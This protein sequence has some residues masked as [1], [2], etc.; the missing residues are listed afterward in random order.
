MG[1][2]GLINKYATT[3]LS[4]ARAHGFDEDSI[5]RQLG[6]AYHD[7]HFSGED[8]VV[9]SREVKLL[10]Q[11]ELCGLTRNR[12]RI[13][14]FQM[15]CQLALSCSTLGAALD[16]AFSFYRLISEDIGFTL[17]EGGDAVVRIWLREPELDRH[18]MLY[19]WWAIFWSHFAGWLIGEE[20]PLMSA[21]FP[22][23]QAGD[24][25]EYAEVLA[26]DCR[27]GR[28]EALVRFDRR[29]LA[30]RLIRNEQD[31]ARF[32]SV[33]RVDLVNMPGV[34]RSFRAQ[35][36]NAISSHLQ[37]HEEFLSMTAVAREF[38]MSSQTLRR[39]LEEYD[40]SYRQIKEEVRREAVMR[41]LR[42]P[43][44]SIG[45]ISL[46]A[47]F[48]EKNG[49]FRAVRSWVGMTP[50]EYRHSMLRQSGQLH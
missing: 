47:G 23:P 3:L 12:V 45:E 1:A 13:G 37:H 40:T 41:W 43:D 30:R 33:T 29:F 42:H 32:I 28:P 26:P 21:E 31:L 22:H 9:I 36:R 46:R 44:I 11:D 50:A 38:G 18:H 35:V 27:F 19:E 14:C 17:E 24:L 6:R 25:A 49:L 15:M 39:R 4:S 8:Y 2:P 10:M 7:G 20:V 16:R 5:R 48:S 34:E